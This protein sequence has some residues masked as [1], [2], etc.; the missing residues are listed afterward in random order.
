MSMF[1]LGLVV[2]VLAIPVGLVIIIGI[3]WLYQKVKESG[4][5]QTVW[6]KGLWYRCSNCRR[7]GCTFR[8][9]RVLPWKVTSILA[10]KRRWPLYCRPCAAR[11]TVY[12]GAAEQAARE[13]RRLNWLWR[14]EECN[15]GEPTECYE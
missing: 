3:E 1:L 14:D 7:W 12:H 2:G 11:M 5:F 8:G 15:G 4:F 13:Q 9:C 6:Y 10:Q